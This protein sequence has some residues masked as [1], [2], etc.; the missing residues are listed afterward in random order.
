[1]I[2]DNISHM[3]RYCALAAGIAEGLRW[4]RDLDGSI[5]EGRYELGGGSYANVERYTTRE[6]NALGFE[7]HCDYIDIQY[8]VA[9]RERVRV[10]DREALACTTPYDARR[11]AAFYH[12]DGGSASEL[13]LGDGMFAIFFPQDAHEPQL[14]AEEPAEVTKAV[15]K[16]RISNNA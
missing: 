13:L 12:D 5:A 9:G 8:L 10:R 14:A 7:S 6:S 11:D 1:M 4:L 16:V 15:V 2:Y 3:D